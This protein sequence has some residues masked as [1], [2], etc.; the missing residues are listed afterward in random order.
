MTDSVW[1]SEVQEYMR[2]REMGG[3]TVV[4]VAV[5]NTVAAALAIKDPVKPEAAGVVAALHTMGIQVRLRF[6]S[7]VLDA[8]WALNLGSVFFCQG[9]GLRF[10]VMV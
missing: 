1:C 8:G 5:S 7:S 2:Q 9:L 4:L 6:N 3:A 10:R